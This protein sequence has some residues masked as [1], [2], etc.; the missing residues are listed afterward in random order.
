MNEDEMCAA[1]SMHGGDEK[2]EQIFPLENFKQ[3]RKLGI[4]RHRWDDSISM[5]LKFVWGV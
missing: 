4:P 2:C 1:C 3:K 5:N